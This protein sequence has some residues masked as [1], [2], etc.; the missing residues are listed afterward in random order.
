[1]PDSKSRTE[2]RRKLKIRDVNKAGSFKAKA[3]SLKTKAKSLKAKAKAMQRSRLRSNS[4][5]YN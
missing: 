5:G 3:K 2:R 4:I 1:V